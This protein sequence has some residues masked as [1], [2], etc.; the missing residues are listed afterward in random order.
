MEVHQFKDVETTT[1]I[2]PPSSASKASR[3]SPLL[4]NER[5]Q[6][7]FMTVIAVEGF[8][9]ADMMLARFKSSILQKI[10]KIT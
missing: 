6:T 1:S 3:S 9:N 4:I 10:M 5:P 8:K 2:S 7:I